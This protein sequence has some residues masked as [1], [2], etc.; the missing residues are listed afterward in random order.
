M[1]SQSLEQGSMAWAGQQ[2]TSQ[3]MDIGEGTAVELQEIS[4]LEQC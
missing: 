1:G 4:V 3:V 2:V